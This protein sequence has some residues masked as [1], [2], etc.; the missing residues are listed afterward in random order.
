VG[1][2]SSKKKSP[3]KNL[4]TKPI[5]ENTPDSSRTIDFRGRLLTVL[6]CLVLVLATF[7]VYWQ[8]TGYDFV[9]LDDNVYVSENSHVQ[10]GLTSDSVIWAFTAT[11]AANWHP[12]TWLSLMLDY[13]LYGLNAGGYHRTNLVLHLANVLLLFFVLK[14][15][16]G[17]LWRS[18]FVAALFALHPL[19][20]ESVAWVTERKD[21][22]STLFWLLT[23]WAYLGYVER[24]GVRRY[25]LIIV[26]LTL[27][28]MAKPMLV[29]LP[30]V[31]LL[32]DY[33]PLGRFQV[34][35]FVDTPEASIQ[36][37][38]KSGQP[39]SALL[40][41]VWE[42]IPLFALAAVSSVVTFL[43]QKSAGAL[44]HFETWPI[45]IRIANAL[46]SY[47]KYLGKMIWPRSLAVFYPHPG[48]SLPSWKAAGAGLLLLC[49][50]IL[51]V[52]RARRY[53]YL[54][55]GWLWY[56]GTLVPVIGLVQAGYQAMADRYTYIP[57]IGLYIIIAWGVAEIVPRWPHRR[58][59][60]ATLSTTLFLFLI[61]LTWKQVQYWKNSISL[62]EHT[63]EVTSD[64]W[65]YNNN[66]GIAL[67][68]AGHSDDAIK[69]Y[70]EALRIKPDY[71]GAHYNLGI[72]LG[73]K[74]LPDE[75]IKHY[76]EAL[77]IKP[78]YAE[79][80]NNL[81]IALDRKGHSDEAI[82]HYLE[83][84][85]IKPDYAEAHN[86]L[87]F[88]LY[89][90]GHSDEAIDHYLQALRIKPDYAKAHY[91]L[92]IAL[93]RKGLPDE[94][95]KHYLEALRIKPDYAEAH[96]NL[97]FALYRKGRSDDAIKHYLEALRIKPDYAG[98][99]YNLGI[100]LGRK[101][102]S[103]EAIKHYLEALRIKP[104]YAEAHNNLGI[105]LARKGDVDAALKHFQ[106]AL[107]INPNFSYAR[108]NLKKALWLQK[109]S[110]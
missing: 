6:V 11:D 75:A 102:H 31:F 96:N 89:R 24:P 22:L 43:A 7:A 56:I 4:Q 99:H 46:V 18:A 80:H 88:A 20:V 67:D 100:A 28:L 109:R 2:R 41:L 32:L 97:G 9:L 61:V 70:L 49:I 74:G 85:R 98:A 84:L 94:A 54:V 83:A 50:S 55:V 91:N 3:K 110:Q 73:R 79:A 66:L 105:A 14:L 33:W 81:G 29:T 35:Q 23:M 10:N 1:K 52:R 93:G 108:D 51:V 86:N 69:H 58:L 76:L 12:L 39:M 26:S 104:D 62:F 44:V 15:M 78:D 77:R 82:D 87:G 8:V 101:G 95:I 64:N 48:H 37:P 21:V 40:S 63:L 59:Y 25:L 30:F 103:D 13:E 92:G 106:K 38:I 34:G 90:K 19:H 68:R 72:A 57:L 42:K 5:S 17:A 71:A 16:T 36:A 47:V 27:G 60:F 53:P 107:Q 65:L 45:T